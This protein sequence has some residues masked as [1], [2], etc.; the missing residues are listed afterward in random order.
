[1]RFLRGEC[2]NK[3]CKY[4]HPKVC[5]FYNSEE[6]CSNPDC[7]FAHIDKQRSRSPGS[8]GQEGGN[9]RMIRFKDPYDGDLACGSWNRPSPDFDDLATKS[10]QLPKP[11]QEVM[12]SRICVAEFVSN[13]TFFDA[14]GMSIGICPRMLQT[15]ICAVGAILETNL[16]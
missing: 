2:S 12:C 14:W 5:K 11:P 16:S 10:E 1:M 13:V 8:D 9:A 6:G 3:N 15:S 4:D 7:T